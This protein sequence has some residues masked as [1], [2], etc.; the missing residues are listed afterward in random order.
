M[1]RCR[2]ASWP[3]RA[4]DA[5][6]LP[7]AAGRRRI[8]V[9]RGPSGC[10]SPAPGQVGMKHG[11][12]PEDVTQLA[13]QLPGTRRPGEMVGPWLERHAHRLHEMVRAGW[14]WAQL[15]E[16]LN[17]AGITYRASVRLPFGGGTSRGAWTAVQLPRA[18]RKAGLRVEAL[19]SARLALV[20]PGQ[21]ASRPASTQAEP[22]PEPAS[23]AA[24]PKLRIHGLEPPQAQGEA[25]PSLLQRHR[26][27]KDAQT[28]AVLDDFFRKKERKG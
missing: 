16:A 27:A 23:A 5:S 4:K 24:R 12:P 2:D 10:R 15:A 9:G 13:A 14:T 11:C 25:E 20:Q 18:V 21:P 17:G 7:G 1:G 28:K 8:H 26:D 3:S 22:A 6:R 19:A